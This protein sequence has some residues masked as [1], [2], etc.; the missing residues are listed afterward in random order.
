MLTKT[1]AASSPGR[2]P[3]CPRAR[4]LASAVAELRAAEGDAVEMERCLEKWIALGQSHLGEDVNLRALLAEIRLPAIP[5][6]IAA[7]ARL[8]RL[9]SLSEAAYGAVLRAEGWQS[10]VLYLCDPGDGSLFARLHARTLAILESSGW[11]GAPIDAARWAVSI[12]IAEQ[13]LE[14][15]LDAPV[16]SMEEVQRRSFT[17]LHQGIAAYRAVLDEDRD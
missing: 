14:P 8:R 11:Q 13:G 10:S 9:K 15:D 12:Y 1:V 16:P 17:A 5:T 6:G 7:D 4:W 3:D 2:P